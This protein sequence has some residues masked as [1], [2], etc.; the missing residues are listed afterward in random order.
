MLD[1]REELL[2]EFLNKWTR[3]A[4]KDMSLERYPLGKDD[5]FCAWVEYEVEELGSI[6][7]SPGGAGKFGLYK[8]KN[9][10]N[11]LPLGF[12]KDEQNYTW[13]KRLGTS[14][15][16][17]F[18][19]VK[20]IVL[21]IIDNARNGKFDNFDGKNKIN[22]LWPMFKWKL[23]F[24][25]QDFNNIKILPVFLKPKLS[26]Y[27]GIK[28]DTKG[29][30]ELYAIAI[31]KYNIKT[32]GE[33]FAFMDK[34]FPPQL[35]D[36]AN[37]IGG[38]IASRREL[39]PRKYNRKNCSTIHSDIQ[40]GLRDYLT[41]QG[42]KVITEARHLKG[43]SSKIDIVSIKEKEK[44]YYEIKPYGDARN[45]I[46]EALGQILEYWY[47]KKSDKYT[48]AD[49][50]VIV[51]P[52]KASKEDRSYLEKIR[53]EHHIPIEYWQFDLEKNKTYS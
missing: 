31:D 1:Y 50:L 16:E 38:G 45:C 17:A 15:E 32:L 22:G 14:S 29:M 5:S 37:Y 26:E 8:Q 27:L 44:I 2:N 23:A 40:K 12:R 7:G 53:N 24:L 3:T 21:D 30:L 34:V 51:G 9:I 18:G 46:R 41:G 25:Y 11:N 35:T 4:V 43:D 42:L 47:Y 19:R 20:K 49:K 13:N 52:E 6:S 33:A 39:P 48:F 36:D 28:D 10:K